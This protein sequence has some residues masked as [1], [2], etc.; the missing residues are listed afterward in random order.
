MKNGS[1]DVLNNFGAIVN[2][3]WKVNRLTFARAP[4]DHEIDRIC[5]CLMK[6]VAIWK[7]IQTTSLVTEHPHRLS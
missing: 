2:L 6:E 4:F 7:S 5:P 3:Y 1:I